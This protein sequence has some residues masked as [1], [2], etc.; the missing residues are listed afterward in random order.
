MWQ[1]YRKYRDFPSV[2][3]FLLALDDKT[4]PKQLCGAQKNVAGWAVS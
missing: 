4:L 2:A 1:V 3:V